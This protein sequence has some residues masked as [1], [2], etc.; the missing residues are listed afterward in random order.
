MPDP[1]ASAESGRGKFR[2]V[3]DERAAE[4]YRSHPGEFDRRAVHRY[5]GDGH[6]GTELAEPA[7]E[8]LIRPEDTKGHGS[9]RSAGRVTPPFRAQPSS[10]RPGLV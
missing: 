7:H 2:D 5:L 8:K 6:A 3:H 4:R 1:E 9:V 10:A